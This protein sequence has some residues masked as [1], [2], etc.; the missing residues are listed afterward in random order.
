MSFRT[1]PYCGPTAEPCPT[2]TIKVDPKELSRAQTTTCAKEEQREAFGC[3]PSVS[4]AIAVEEVHLR[5]FAC[6]EPASPGAVDGG[7]G[8]STCTNS[9]GCRVDNPMEPEQEEIFLDDDAESAQ[10]PSASL[11]HYLNST[12]RPAEELQQSGYSLPPT[13]TMCRGIPPSLSHVLIEEPQ[14]PEGLE[15]GAEEMQP[16][17]DI[18]DEAVLVTENDVIAQAMPPRARTVPADFGRSEESEMAFGVGASSDINEEPSDLVDDALAV[19]ESEEPEEVEDQSTALALATEHL[20]SIESEL[21]AHRDLIAREAEAR[22]RLEDALLAERRRAEVEAQG[23]RRLEQ[24]IEAEKQR[25]E[26]ERRRKQEAE[27]MAIRREKERRLE[28]ELAEAR[29]RTEEEARLAE[30]RS[31]EQR[32]QAEKRR[33]LQEMEQKARASAAEAKKER[34]SREKAKAF[35][36]AEGYRHV[37]AAHKWS[38][39][40]TYPL[41][42]A[43]QCN[44][45]QMVRLLLWMGADVKQSNTFGQTP[46]SLAK[47]LNRRDSHAEVVA[48]LQVVSRD[49]G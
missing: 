16:A 35:L 46:L 28:E 14:V 19:E 25:I 13:R 6:A 45:P 32:R 3:L 17:E 8:S 10:S 24:E 29:R 44:D 42:R 2:D 41:H 30:E 39:V 15:V 12:R 9:A 27:D 4:A 49:G 11:A 21:Q 34:E 38:P 43:V 22:R 48:A 18:V 20:Q 37:R 47:W 23:R 31:E 26:D 1:F 33:Q 5:S 7:G 40:A 36:A